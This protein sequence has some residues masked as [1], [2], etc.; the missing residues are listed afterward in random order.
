MRITARWVAPLLLLALPGAA[1]A[2]RPVHP[3]AASPAGIV[4]HGWSGGSTAVP[5]ASGLFVRSVAD[6]ASPAHAP[7]FGSRHERSFVVAGALAGAVV[8][9]ALV[10]GDKGLAPCTTGG[11][12]AFCAGAR[13]LVVGA[14]AGA[15]ALVGLL[16]SHVWP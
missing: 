11:S 12:A 1:P 6:G 4:W 8:S 16:A 13:V 10:A 3:P 2:Q 14:A 15:G 9:G 7:S 5:V